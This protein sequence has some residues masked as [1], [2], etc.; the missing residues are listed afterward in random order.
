MAGL[1]K[2]C[3][4]SLRPAHLE[5]VNTDTLQSVQLQ[6]CETKRKLEF[7]LYGVYVCVCMCTYVCMQTPQQA[8]Q[9]LTRAR[10]IWMSRHSVTT[11]R[12]LCTSSVGPHLLSSGRSH[13]FLH[14]VNMLSLN[15]CPTTQMSGGGSS[16]DQPVVAESRCVSV[17]SR[18]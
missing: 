8:L 18:K 4:L 13:T 5:N 2:K 9:H 1:N 14:S 10:G 15:T 12:R 3:N 11:S 16:S 17:V 7:T 6:H